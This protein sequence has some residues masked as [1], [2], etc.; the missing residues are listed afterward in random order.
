M[1]QILKREPVYKGYSTIER[2]TA[3]LDNGV[4]ITRE[5]ESHGRA[6]AVLPY[7]PERRTALLVRQ[8]RAPVMAASGAPSLLE[9]PAG[10]IDGDDTAEAS[11]RREAL[12]EVGL[13]LGD[14]ERV[15]V[16]W[17]SS[18]VSTE[19]MTLYLA[20]YAAADRIA[21]GGGLDSEQEHI[22]VVETPLADLARLGQGDEAVDMKLML[23]T[24]ALRL[25]RPDL[26]A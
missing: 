18:G 26:F 10:M 24:Q 8:F 5:V 17:P 4:E 3:R 23:L 15:A 14:I 11:V 20:Q 25:K 21:P 22:T 19:T 13:K 12:E 6:V 16:A 9:A 1:A 7:D 2:V